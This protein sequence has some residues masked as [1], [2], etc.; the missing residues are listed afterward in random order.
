MEEV[1]FYLYISYGLSTLQCVFSV[2]RRCVSSALLDF[3]FL[4]GRRVSGSFFNK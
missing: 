4:E 1:T 2:I 3:K